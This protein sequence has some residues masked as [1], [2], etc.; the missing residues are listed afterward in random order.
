MSAGNAVSSGLAVRVKQGLTWS[1]I[2]NVVLRLSSLLIGILLARILSPETFGIYAVG[3]TAQTILQT[4]ADLGLSADLIRHGDIARR[5]PTVATIG[6]VTSIVLALLTCL[7]AEPVALLLGDAAG[8]PVIRVLAITLVLSG[9]AA[10]P[11]AIAQREF[12]QKQQFAADAGGLLI[13]T[14]TTLAL[15]ALGFG[16]MALAWSRVAGQ[17][18]TTVIQFRF[19]GTIPRFGFDPAVAKSS[20]RFGTPLAAANLLSWILLNLDYMIVGNQGRSV[21]LGFYVLAFNLSSWPSTALGNALR[22]VTFPAFAELADN[23]FLLRRAVVATTELAWAVALPIGFSLIVFATPLI[24]VI[25]GDKWSISSGP[26][27]GLAGFGVLRVVFDVMATFLIA[28]GE[29]GQILWIQALWLFALAPSV[30]LS[31]EWYGITGVGWAHVVV[32]LAFV[33]PMYLAAMRKHG[34]RVKELTLGPAWPVAA[35]VIAALLAWAA[36]RSL[37]NEVLALL[38]GGS[39]G[40]AAYTALTFKWVMRRLKAL[41]VPP[42]EPPIDVKHLASEEGPG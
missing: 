33:Y 4:L 31:M 21:T 1:L 41:K 6:L 12:M 17:T 5:A 7:V 16:A 27:L 18:Y 30:W 14:I 40:L 8:A 25:Y 15:V 10:V 28:K 36:S 2:N 3:L 39:V 29:S 38:G 35:A 26:L 23:G 32:A 11:F 19:T 9:S 42:G 24:S 34:L 13:T 22:T 20:L 37:N